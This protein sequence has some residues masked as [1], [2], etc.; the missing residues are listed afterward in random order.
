MSVALPSVGCMAGDL[1]DLDAAG[2]L[3]AASSAV[4]VRRLAEVHDLRVLAQ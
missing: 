3:A 4:R 2:L 1:F